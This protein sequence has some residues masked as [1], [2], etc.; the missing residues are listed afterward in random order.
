MKRFAFTPVWELLHLLLMFIQ[1]Y[2]RQRSVPCSAAFDHTNE[3]ALTSSTTPSLSF[4]LSGAEG[5][6]GPH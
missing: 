3:A 4:R 5:L 2:L 1:P 6:G